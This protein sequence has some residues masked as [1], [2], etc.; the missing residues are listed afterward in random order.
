MNPFVDILNVAGVSGLVSGLEYCEDRDVELATTDASEFV[1]DLVSKTPARQLTIAL[2]RLAINLSDRHPN[3]D[4]VMLGN[5][6]ILQEALAS[7]HHRGAI[8]VIVS[9]QLTL[10]QASL[11]ERNAPRK[12]SVKVITP[13]FVPIIS[14]NSVVLTIGFEGGGGY[15]LVDG[16]AFIALGAV[17]G[18]HFT[19]EVVALL[20][21]GEAQVHERPKNW[22]LV[23]RDLFSCICRPNGFDVIKPNI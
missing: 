5:D 6:L 21:F 10:K 3:T 13:G 12:G 17:R 16:D 18:Q 14:A 1:P 22:R 8:Q 2:Y 9:S 4:L 11:I 20:P 15:L 19:G 23:R 7:I